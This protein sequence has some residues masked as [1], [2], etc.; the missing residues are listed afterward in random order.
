VGLFE[1]DNFHQPRVL[2]HYARRVSDCSLSFTG[3]NMVSCVHLPQSFE[4]NID[5]T[6]VR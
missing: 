5:G 4:E 1:G 2:S 3:G 6:R